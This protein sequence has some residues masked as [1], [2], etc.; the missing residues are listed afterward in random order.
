MREEKKEAEEKKQ[1]SRVD[2]SHVKVNIFHRNLRSSLQHSMINF[3]TASFSICTRWDNEF[4]VGAIIHRFSISASVLHKLHLQFV[5]AGDESVVWTLWWP[6]EGGGD[7]GN[8][9]DMLW[10]YLIFSLGSSKSYRINLHKYSYT[11]HFCTKSFTLACLIRWN[12]IASFATRAD[13]YHG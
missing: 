3:V 7:S 2:G 6:E 12:I 11:D 4:R 5:S 13:T 8:Q 9:G 1:L 10:I